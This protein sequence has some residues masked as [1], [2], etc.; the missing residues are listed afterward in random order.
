[1][2]G[3]KQLLESIGGIPVKRSASHG[4]VSQIVNKFNEQEKMILAVAPEGTRSPILPW[5]T[6]FLSIAHQANVPVL[7][8]GFDFGKKH[9]IIGPLMKTQGDTQADISIIYNFFRPIQA[10]YPQDVKYPEA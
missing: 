4:V 10:K 9:V 6:G 8:I 5:K 2:P 1:V 7:L 3:I